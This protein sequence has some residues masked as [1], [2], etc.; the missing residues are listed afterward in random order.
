MRFL[1]LL[2]VLV[3]AVCAKHVAL[4]FGVH[5]GTD[6]ALAVAAAPPA[7]MV[8]RDSQ[9]AVTLVNKGTFY[10]VNVLLGADKQQVGVI[11][12]TG[13][14][15]LWVTSPENPQCAL[16]K[17]SVGK[18]AVSKYALLGTYDCG[19]YGTF[20]PSSSLL[21][22]WND[23]LFLLR[24]L[25]S[26]YVLGK[27][28]HDRVAVGGVLLELLLFAVAN[29]TNAT[30]LVLGIGLPALEGTYAYATSSQTAYQYENLPMRLKLEGV[31]DKVMYLLFL[32]QRTSTEG[33]LLFGDI[34][35]SKY[36]GDLHTAPMVP[37]GKSNQ[38]LHMQL[39]LQNLTVN[40]TD[41]WGGLG[42]VVFD[43][44][45]TY[46]QMPSAMMDQLVKT[47]LLEHLLLYGGWYGSCK[48]LPDTKM[49][50]QFDG[51]RLDIPVANFFLQLSYN[52]GEVLDICLLAMVALSGV[53]VLGDSFLRLVYAVFDLEEYEISLAYAKYGDGTSGGD[54][55]PFDGELASI[56]ASI[57]ASSLASSTTSGRLSSTT[58]SKSSGASRTPSSSSS[59]G[60]ASASL[61]T[62]SVSPSL[63]SSSLATLSFSLTTFSPLVTVVPS[64][65]LT[66]ARTTASTVSS[67]STTSSAGSAAHL[68]PGLLLGALLALV[69]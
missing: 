63:N 38:Y 32:G 3:A 44:G 64:S 31:I 12:D 57:L 35:S 45:A 36:T 22:A 62:A 67:A 50:F 48:A 4:D 42:A 11:I 59:L 13:L 16:D 26:L 43:T 27:W 18:N 1:L 37:Y 14:S 9:S 28:G 53:Y 66:T 24:Y 29:W 2:L 60:T 10:M 61:G 54:V 17:S 20:E 47:M 5:R 7:Q 34:D 69:S 58:L 15:D 41:L 51:F 30:V 8:R 25:D 39:A 40:G 23:T 52:T 56:L 33:S 55:Q 65:T 49:A 68:A 21:F 6:R 19:E 46:C